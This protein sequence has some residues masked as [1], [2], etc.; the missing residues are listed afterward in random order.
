MEPN[1][2]RSGREA[3]SLNED[4]L[5]TIELHFSAQT[6]SG[7][8]QPERG[9]DLDMYGGLRRP[10]LPEIL[11]R[12]ITALPGV[13]YPIPVIIIKVDDEGERRECCR[14]GSYARG[15]SE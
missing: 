12:D 14:G 6:D 5:F 3:R 8:H 10:Q 13:R 7:L 2:C 9:A 4:P 15:R 1:F 11:A